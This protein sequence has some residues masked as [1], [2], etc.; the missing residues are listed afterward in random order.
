MPFPLSADGKIVVEGTDLIQA[1]AAV[2]AELK[3]AKPSTISITGTHIEFTAGLFRFVTKWSLLGPIG[4]GSI[5]FQQ[6][7]GAVEVRYHISFVQL[8]IVVTMMVILVFG[9]LP[10]LSWGAQARVPLPMLVVMWLWLFGMNY[11]IT[12]FAFR[13]ALG[14]ALRKAVHAHPGAPATRGA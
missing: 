10:G 9:L 3:R 7:A 5:A 11:L 14:G 8:F 4:S 12:I 2:E 13:I 6:M 1:I